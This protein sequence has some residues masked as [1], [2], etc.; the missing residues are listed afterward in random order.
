MALLPR[1]SMILLADWIRRP[2]S[3]SLYLDLSGIL[4]YGA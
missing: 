3:L 2:P 4:L 1:I